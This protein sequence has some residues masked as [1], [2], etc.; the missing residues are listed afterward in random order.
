ME[1]ESYL[2]SIFPSAQWS[3]QFYARSFAGDS[4][5]ILSELRSGV[6]QSTILSLHVPAMKRATLSHRHGVW[7][8]SVSHTVSLSTKKDAFPQTLFLLVLA[9]RDPT[10]FLAKILTQRGYSFTY[11]CCVIEQHGV[12]REGNVPVQCGF[13]VVVIQSVK[14]GAVCGRGARRSP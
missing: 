1:Q 9:G 13:S 8:R 3:K 14:S 2:R 5:F 11:A 4:G 12:P 6:R 7:R 10:R